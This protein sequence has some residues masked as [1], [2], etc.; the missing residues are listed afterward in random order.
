MGYIFLWR[1]WFYELINLLFTF[2]IIF[3]CFSH[4]FTIALFIFNNHF[5]YFFSFFSV[6]YWWFFL[7][8]LPSKKLMI[9]RS[10]RAVTI[11]KNK[12]IQQNQPSPT[13]TPKILPPPL[14]SRNLSYTNLN[15]FCKRAWFPISNKSSCKK[16]PH[17]SKFEIKKN[18]WC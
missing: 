6:S 17:K 18:I 11:Q 9:S 14:L 16:L 3:I 1:G 12:I 15:L 10:G 7:C 13:P 2:E 5:L 4:H 8:I